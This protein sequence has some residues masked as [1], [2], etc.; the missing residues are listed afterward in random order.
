ME[1]IFLFVENPQPRLIGNAIGI[2]GA[3]EGIQGIPILL[4]RPRRQGVGRNH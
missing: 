1:R 2:E 3:R 4:R